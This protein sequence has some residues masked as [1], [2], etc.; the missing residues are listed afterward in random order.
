MKKVIVI[1]GMFFTSISAFG[2]GQEFSPFTFVEQLNP[3]LKR[4]H[5][6]IKDAI[7]SGKTDLAKAIIEDLLFTDRQT[8]LF[9]LDTS[10]GCLLHHAAGVG[11]LDI[12]KYLVEEQ[13]MDVNLAENGGGIVPLLSAVSGKREDVVRYLMEH[14]ADANR[15]DIFGDS[16]LSIAIMYNLTNIIPLLRNNSGS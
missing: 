5:S 10:G 14:G 9:T 6:D 13:H 15:K 2:T 8:V 7:S 3:E 1:V 11:A 12:V 4:A 16:P